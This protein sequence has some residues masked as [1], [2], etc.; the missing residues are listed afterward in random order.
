MANTEHP[1]SFLK[2]GLKSPSSGVNPASLKD[3]EHHIQAEFF[4]T[5]LPG[6]SSEHIIPVPTKKVQKEQ[7]SLKSDL[8]LSCD[9]D[10]ARTHDPQLRRLLL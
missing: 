1:F 9:S 10:G 5:A 3:S 8:K 2:D 6:L 4:E 7:E